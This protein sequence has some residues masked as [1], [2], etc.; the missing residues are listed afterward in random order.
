MNNRWKKNLTWNGIMDQNLFFFLSFSS[1]YS[2]NDYT[3]RKSVLCATF[4]IGFYNSRM[5]LFASVWIY[6]D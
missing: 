2:I 5:V 1:W 3:V 6:D 4:P